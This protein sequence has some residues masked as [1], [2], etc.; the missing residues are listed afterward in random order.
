MYFGFCFATKIVKH[1]NEKSYAARGGGGG[2][3][4]KG[5]R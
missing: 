5:A 3:S 2:E 1:S 4:E